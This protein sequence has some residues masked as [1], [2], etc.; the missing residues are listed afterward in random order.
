MSS[1]LTF[2]QDM[3][4]WAVA[5]F[6][7]IYPADK[8]EGR[9]IS[10]FE[11]ATQLSELPVGLSGNINFHVEQ[12]A[13]HQGLKLFKKTLS[14]RG[15]EF[16]GKKG[17]SERVEKFRNLPRHYEGY[18]VK[19]TADAAGAGMSS[20]KLHLPGQVSALVK[21][22]AATR[23]SLLIAA[24]LPV[25]TFTSQDQFLHLDLEGKLFN[26]RADDVSSSA[27]LV[28]PTKRKSDVSFDQL[29]TDYKIRIARE[30]GEAVTA[31]IDAAASAAMYSP[32]DKQTLLGGK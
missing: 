19:M 13:F 21:V 1:S 3:A 27:S 30:G 32:A 25:S 5:V 20:R 14:T 17:D 24:K 7:T 15:F 16:E 6:I 4:A 2:E 22:V 23:D 29:T 28:I 10:M 12:A 8:N 26:V 31:A 18:A 11:I 9:S